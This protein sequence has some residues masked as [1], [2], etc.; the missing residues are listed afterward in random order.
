[1]K[2]DKRLEKLEVDFEVVI[3]EPAK[4]CSETAK[5]RGVDTSQIV[6]SL[7]IESEGEK[8]HVC[9]PGDRELS[10]G[11]FGSEYRMVPPEE[12][13]NITG[14]EP[15]TVHPFSSDL[16]HFVDERV[17][18]HENVSH[19]VGS[20]EKGVITAVEEFRQALE[21]SNFD[22]EVSDIVVS[23][24]EDINEIMNL[25][26][27]ESEAK[28]VVENGFRNTFKN[29]K[30][31]F[32]S[33]RILDLLKAFDRNN[34]S[35]QLGEEIL[36]RAENQ[37]HLQKLVEEVVKTGELLDKDEEGDLEE[38]IS[39]VLSDNTDAVE[40]LKNGKD[41]T[42]NYLLG[43]VMQETNGKAD[44]GEARELIIEEV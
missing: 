31:N 12:A 32:D 41:S 30:C 39:Q 17:F 35:V 22:F 23:T 7:I 21:K 42:I 33:S 44:A 36:E 43:Q 14:F 26:L 6:K 27:G 29:L 5:R 1:M 24:Q 18:E 11:K 34:A 40:D 37:T 38:V 4:K 2:A 16:R 20:P 19:T 13:E 28:F 15:G 10:E 3:H 9:L 25:G 8:F